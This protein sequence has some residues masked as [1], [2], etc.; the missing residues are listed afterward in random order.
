[1]NIKKNNFCGFIWSPA[2]I[3]TDDILE[4][5]NKIYPVLHYYTY[6]FNNQEKYEKSILDIYTTDDIDPNKVKNVKIQNMIKYSFSYTY[7]KF[8]IEKPN[9]RKKK[10]TGTDISQVVENIKK[11]IRTSYMGKLKNYIHDIIIH[12]SDNFEQTNDIDIIM[13]KY[14]NFKKYEFIN[15]KYFLKYNFNNNIFD[16]VDMLVRKYSI[17]QYLKN[18]NY[19]FSLYKKMQKKRTNKDS[20][21]YVINFK[22]LI[23]SLL[24]NG[25]NINYPIKY[26]K[27]YLLRDGSHRLSY[28]YLNNK[29]FIPIKNMPW[30]NHKTYSVNWF[31]NNKFSNNELNIINNE[32]EKLNIFLMN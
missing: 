4:Y 10:A 24:N 27:N 19:D 16:R 30:D 11:K 29:I 32:I 1:M 23:N 18:N 6:E 5:I 7:F 15:L 17:E 21:N 13:K 14:E 8:F 12:I 26:S 25:F 3:F 9:F 2:I 28:L 31:I 20:E 22:K